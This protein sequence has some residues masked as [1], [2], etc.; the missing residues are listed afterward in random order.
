MR[1]IALIFAA[2]VLALAAATLRKEGAAAV[3]DAKDSAVSNAAS[4]VALGAGCNSNSDCKNSNE[5][6]GVGG[7]CGSC[8]TGGGK[9]QRDSQCCSGY[10]CNGSK[11]RTIPSCQGYHDTKACTSNADC[12]SGFTCTAQDGGLGPS[13]YWCT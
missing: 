5:V 7:K 8:N 6:C 12:C 4:S 3:L 13:Y 1:A 9:C 10:S 11:C 2:A